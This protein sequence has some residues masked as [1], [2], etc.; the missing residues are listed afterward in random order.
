MNTQ[1]VAKWFGIVLLIIGIL[2]FI[3]GV[4]SGNG[5]LFGIFQ[6]DVIHNIIHILAGFI[7]IEVAATLKGSKNYFKIFGIIFGLIAIVGFANNGGVL[8][9]T[10]NMADNILNV[11]IALIALYYGFAPEKVTM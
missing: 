9:M 11:V 4:V 3:P 5:L 2:G 8:I 6:V 10:M 7:G 1:N